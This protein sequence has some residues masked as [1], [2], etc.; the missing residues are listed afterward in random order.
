M[1]LGTRLCVLGL[2][3][4]Q[5]WALSQGQALEEQTSGQVDILAFCDDPQVKEAV[6]GALKT[7]NSKMSSGYKMA[8]YQITQATKA[9]NE[10]GTVVSA[11]FNSKRSNCPAEGDKPW[12]ECDYLDGSKAPS[13]CNTTVYVTEAETLVQA[14]ICELDPPVVSEKSQCMGCPMEIDQNNE[15]LKAP[16]SFSLNRFNSVS[17][18]SHFF[19]I[20]SVGYATRQVVAGL[21]FSIWFDMRKSNCSKADNQE[22]HSACHPDPADVELAHCSSTVDVAPWRHELPE[23]NVDCEPGPMPPTVLTRRRPPGWSPLRNVIDF[24]AK[25]PETTAAT[26]PSTSPTAKEESSEESQEKS[27]PSKPTQD[28]PAPA[29]SP[30]RC[31]SKPWKEFVPPTASVPEGTTVSGPP[32]QGEGFRDADLQA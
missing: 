14:V 26:P 19:V 3:C 31:P 16:L 25:V 5:D 9:V 21:R 28:P 27:D 11:L 7:F 6:D 29:D 20:N 4:L 2:L 8:L 1:R 30:F 13:P 12:S 10:S 17:N 18:S 23:G 15:D 24:E 32:E 22:L